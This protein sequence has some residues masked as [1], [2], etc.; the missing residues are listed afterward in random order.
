MKVIKVVS[1]GGGNGQSQV[2]KAM[3]L[4]EKYLQKELPYFEVCATFITAANDDGFS[5]GRLRETYE[6]ICGY[7]GDV[8]RNLGAL[9]SVI[10]GDDWLPE[11]L[12]TRIVAGV[13]EGQP[14]GDVLA[15]V[16]VDGSTPAMQASHRGE[17]IRDICRILKLDEMR[18]GEACESLLRASEYCLKGDDFPHHSV[19]NYLLFA[20]ER[21]ALQ[22]GL[23]LRD[24]LR[25]MHCIY[26]IPEKYRVVPVIWKPGVLKARTKSGRLIEG[27]YPIDFRESDPFR[28][29]D[30]IQKLWVEPAASPSPEALQS[31]HNADIIIIPCGSLWGN[32]IA[33]FAIPEMKDALRKWGEQKNANGLPAP[34]IYVM[35]LMTKVGETQFDKPYTA[36]NVLE[37]VGTAIGRWPTRVIFNTSILPDEVLR[38]YMPEQQIR[39]GALRRRVGDPR[40]E[41]QKLRFL[42]KENVA[43]V[44]P[45]A[46]PN[47]PPK[48]LHDPEKLARVFADIILSDIMVGALV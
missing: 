47:L 39:L 36:D 5:T 16:L 25:A 8:G 7:Y 42:I 35:N 15:R 13:K 44:V 43:M 41:S 12:A 3:V 18:D 33:T 38:R 37:L 17:L 31:I 21:I 2:A 40:Y 10:H 30:E 26:R 11:K 23:E 24:G 28:W 22:R 1:I 32:V 14:F 6:G 4:A 45:D 20:L 19:R 46:N 48:I 27:Q 34:L 29:F 9:H